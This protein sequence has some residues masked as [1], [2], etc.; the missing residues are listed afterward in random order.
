MNLKCIEKLE[1][2]TILDKLST[3]CVTDL[4]KTLCYNLKP[5]C[6]R[7]TVLK[8]LQETLEATLLLTE[9]APYFVNIGNIDYIL[10]ILQSD[11]SLNIASIL[12]LTQILKT[13]A[14]L[15]NYF[16]N[17]R[18]I[19]KFPTSDSYFSKLYTNP[20]IIKAV[21]NSILDENT[22]LDSASSKLSSIRKEKKKLEDTIKDK[23]N[24]FIHSSTYSKYVQ[25]SVITIR[26]NRY[27]VPIKDEYRS[28]VKG[29]IHDVSA[30]RFY[31]FY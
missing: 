14:D 29:F 9:N 30:S 17:E 10:K 27:V 2:L 13:S 7:D 16:Y 15:K 19:N 18:D 5:N 31:C 1:Y 25:E 21:E 3:F 28:M 22:I 12:Q 24:G 23:L 20:S 6:N 4:G 8:L 11:G 26:N